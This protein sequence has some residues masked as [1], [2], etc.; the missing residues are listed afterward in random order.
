MTKSRKEREEEK[1]FNDKVAIS[2]GGKTCKQKGCN[3]IVPADSPNSICESC[4]KKV[5]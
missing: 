1:Y 4:W 2:K 5:S 3:N